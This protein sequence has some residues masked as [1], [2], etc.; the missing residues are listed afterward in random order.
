M[1]SG[2]AYNHA[3]GDVRRDAIL[4]AKAVHSRWHTPWPEAMK[5]GWH[6]AHGLQ[7]E[8][9]RAR[10]ECEILPELEQAEEDA[11]RRPL[12]HNLRMRVYQL[13]NELDAAKLARRLS[14][15]RGDDMPG[16]G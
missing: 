5:E 14:Y 6:Q 11:Y 4:F 7:T 13:Q 16:E 1:P 8:M 10:P 9:E 3:T 15:L 2:Y 12:D